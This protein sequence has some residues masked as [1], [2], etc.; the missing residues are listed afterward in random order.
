MQIFYD[1]DA[2][3]SY[4]EGKKIGVIGYGS[5][6]HAQA[7]NLF[8]SGCDVVVGLRPRS[9]SRAKAERAV[10]MDLVPERS[11]DRP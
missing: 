6:G 3:P 8:D 4:L 2:D 11:F 1:R 10:R 5:Q 7:L 9:C